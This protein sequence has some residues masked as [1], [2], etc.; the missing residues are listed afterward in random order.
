EIKDARQWRQCGFAACDALGPAA[1]P[2]IPNLMNLLTNEKP[3]EPDIPL[4][5]ARMG[6]GGIPALSCAL[7]N[8]EKAIRLGARLC[9]DM[10]RAASL[11]LHPK[12]RPA[13]ARDYVYRTCEYHQM[14]LG[15]AHRD[16][17]AQHGTNGGNLG[18]KPFP[19]PKQF[20]AIQRA[21]LQRH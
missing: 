13:E 7:T 10:G 4:L 20:E 6:P 2:I 9:L 21:L 19:D 11:F 15:A 8:D 14:L 16:F 17:M 12:K 3:V 18:D 1:T 5:L